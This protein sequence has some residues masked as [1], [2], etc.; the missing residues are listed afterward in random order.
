[1]SKPITARDYMSATLVTF[2]P[3]TDIHAAINQLIEKRISGAP[4][5]DKQG[6]LV[7][8]LSEKDCLQTALHASYH[9][10]SAGT[11]AEYMHGEVKTVD[12]EASIADV[13]AMFIRDD[14]RRYPVMSDNRLVGQISRRD[15][16]RALEALW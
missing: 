11:V 4:V 1:M 8:I 15:V 12:A 3:D 2:T 6:N 10:E 5:V 13:A 16:L 9:G 14:Y 7:G